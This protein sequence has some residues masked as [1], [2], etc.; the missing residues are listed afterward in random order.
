M[1]LYYYIKS[2]NILRN[3]F[4]FLKL[5]GVKYK[6]YELKTWK[7]KGFAFMNTMIISAFDGCGK[8]YLFDNQKEL[9]F[10]YQ[11]KTIQLSFADCKESEYIKGEGWEESFVDYVESLIG[12]VD[13]IFIPLC[14]ELL[15]ELKKRHIPVCIII[16]NNT[17][18]I[19]IKERMIIEQQ[20]LGRLLLRDFSSISD[21]NSWVKKFIHDYSQFTTDEYLDAYQPRTFYLLNQRQF[22]SDIITDFYDKKEKQPNVY[23]KMTP[24]KQDT[25]Y[26][27]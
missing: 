9:T 21:M 22:I 11:N 25:F 15:T 23:C 24:E 26:H 16:P 3:G 20:W 18:W 5:R 19:S 6:Y 2:K 27:R 8:T 17:K 13:F 7:L 14:N 1:S 12:N 10:N 4:C